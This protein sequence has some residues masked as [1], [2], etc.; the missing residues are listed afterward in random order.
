MK[1]VLITV[2]SVLW[3]TACNKNGVPSGTSTC[4]KKEILINMD[5][6]DWQTGAVEEYTFQNKNSICFSSRWKYYSR[7]QYHYQR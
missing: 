5:N 4:I 6:P 1:L 7:W 3:L 2:L